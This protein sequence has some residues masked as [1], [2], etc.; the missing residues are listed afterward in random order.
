VFIACNFL[1]CY[2][3]NCNVT[4]TFCHVVSSMPALYLQATGDMLVPGTVRSLA[5]GRGHGSD[6][7]SV[8]GL[9]L[10]CV[11]VTSRIM[12][13]RSTTDRTYDSGPIRL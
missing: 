1:C 3:F 12:M 11:A 8:A 9:G 5:V 6:V 2:R 7:M 4:I 13:F 10:V